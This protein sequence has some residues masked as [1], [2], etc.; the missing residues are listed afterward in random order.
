VAFGRAG[1][2]SADTSVLSRILPARLAYIRYIIRNQDRMVGTT[3]A[4]QTDLAGSHFCGVRGG[5]IAGD[6]Q[7]GHR[8]G[9]P[10]KK[11]RYGRGGQG[12]RHRRRMLLTGVR[13]V[14]LRSVRIAVCLARCG[15]LR[16]GRSPLLRICCRTGDPRLPWRRVVSGSRRR[17]GLVEVRQIAAIHGFR[18]P[19]RLGRSRVLDQDVSSAVLRGGDKTP[20][21]ALAF[22]SAST[23]RPLTR[24]V[25]DVVA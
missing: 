2:H 15:R 25:H 5:R 20:A 12:A 24:F 22:R 4:G 1:F 16:V 19:V 18:L 10:Q 23:W 17:S 6:S 8:S 7:K 13:R 14:E 21:C 9:E 3:D 11:N